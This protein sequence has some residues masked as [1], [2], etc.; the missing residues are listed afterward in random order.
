M[1]FLKALVPAAVGALALSACGGETFQSAGTGG[2]AG[3]SGGTAG[4]SGSS[5]GGAA[6]S[7]GTAGGGGSGG[8]DCPGIAPT[9]DTDCPQGLHCSYEAGCCS[10]E[11]ACTEGS[12]EYQGCIGPD[13]EPSCPPSAPGN[14]AVCNLC[15]DLAKCDYDE[16]ETVGMKATATCDGDSWSTTVEPCGDPY[17]CEYGSS[18]GAQFDK[19]CSKE[20]DCAALPILADCCGTPLILGINERDLDE[21]ISVWGQC[22]LELQLCGCP[23]GLPLAEDGNSTPNAGD[24]LVRCDA[25]TCRSYVAATSGT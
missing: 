4:S 24:I 22:G 6:G 23:S 7:G 12:W 8:A 20:T 17:V 16:C 3:S 21:A 14:G 25:G 15:F 13:V 1:W 2:S 9:P 18:F 5:G 19:S 11:Y 10:D